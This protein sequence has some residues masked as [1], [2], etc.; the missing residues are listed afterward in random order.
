V[1]RTW[2]RVATASRI[3]SSALIGAVVVTQFATT[4]NAATEPVEVRFTGSAF[5]ASLAREW[6][7][8][9]ITK[10]SPVRLQFLSQSAPSGRVALLDRNTDA[11]VSPFPFSEAENETLAEQ[12]AAGEKPTF[13]TVPISASGLTFAELN[14]LGAIQKPTDASAGYRDVPPGPTGYSSEQL[15]TWI[16]REAPYPDDPDYAKAHGY[17]AFDPNDPNTPRDADDNPIPGPDD[18]TAKRV[19]GPNG[20]TMRVGPTEENFMMERFMRD[21]L[22]AMWT[23]YNPSIGRTVPGELGRPRTADKG[24]S[25]EFD[26]AINQTLQLWGKSVPFG[27]FAAF[28][29]GVIQ[30]LAMRPLTELGVPDTPENRTKYALRTLSVDGVAPTPEKIGL[31]IANSD[32]L[33][34]TDATIPDANGGYPMSFIN[35]LIVRTDKMTIA[36]A[37]ATASLIRYAVQDGQK[38]AEKTATAPLPDFHVLKALKGANEIIKAVCPTAERVRSTGKATVKGEEISLD[39][40]GPKVAAPATTTTTTVAAVTTTTLASTTTSSIAAAATTTTTQPAAVLNNNTSR[41]PTPAAKPAPAK[42]GA[43]IAT[44]VPP[45]SAPPA[46]ATTAISTTTTVKKKTTTATTEPEP[47][48]SGVQPVTRPGRRRSSALPLFLGAVVF[49]I[50]GRIAKRRAGDDSL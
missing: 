38:F 28:A 48:S 47:T 6:Q 2:S 36:K 4:S 18:F 10:N 8:D 12:V 21:R 46:T 49:R 17:K 42:A 7:L 5:L 35:K 39:E 27:L 25:S 3:V 20:L 31:A 34:T 11:A 1:K 44:T 14:P 9:L 23:V 41:T 40:C 16:Y 13:V 29:P 19:N 22:P 45:T 37:N 24:S 26:Q 50:G 33:S 30:D 43:S 15:L 32:G